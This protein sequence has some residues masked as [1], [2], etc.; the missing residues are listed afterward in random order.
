MKLSD[1]AL[2]LAQQIQS[3]NDSYETRENDFVK[4]YKAFENGVDPDEIFDESEDYST[5]YLEPDFYDGCKSGRYV[6]DSD[7][8]YVEDTR[9]GCSVLRTYIDYYA[10]NEERTLDILAS[11]YFNEI[12]NLDKLSDAIERDLRDMA[13]KVHSELIDQGDNDVSYF[14]VLAFISDYVYLDDLLCY[15]AGERDDTISALADLFYKR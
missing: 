15:R 12:D 6:L 2:E 11:E 8:D 10:D 7:G 5:E 9:E 13:D 14:D 4:A 1:L 3:F